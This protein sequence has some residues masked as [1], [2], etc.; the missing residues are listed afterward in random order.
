MAAARRS[1]GG[2]RVREG[3]GGSY[4]REAAAAGLG[5]LRWRRP[6]EMRRRPRV[7]EARWRLQGDAAAAAQGGSDENRRV[8]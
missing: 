6:R 1:N 4:G 7:E 2:F 5:E 3:C 8:N